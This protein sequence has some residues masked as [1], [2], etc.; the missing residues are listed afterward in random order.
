M[1]NS[2]V[3]AMALVGQQHQ[4]AHPA[5][6]HPAG[7]PS[8]HVG[9]VHAGAVGVHP[10]GHAA[11]AMEHQVMQAI[12]QHEAHMVQQ[13]QMQYQQHVATVNHDL[14]NVEDYFKKQRFDRRYW[15]ELRH[16]HS[17]LGVEPFWR[18]ARRHR[19]I[20]RLLAALRE[21]KTHVRQDSTEGRLARLKAKH[22][23]WDLLAESR[24]FA[25]L[26]ERK[27]D[28]RYW[29]SMRL[30]YE[31]LGADRFWLLARDHREFEPFRLALSTEL[32]KQLL[33]GLDVDTRPE[34]TPTA[35]PNSSGM[36]EISP[37]EYKSGK[38][39]ES[40]AASPK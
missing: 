18:L 8:G 24:F 7:H 3:L 15:D 35:K 19:E 30:Y 31:R 17:R 21:E 12:V 38:T 28:H 16:H 29:E 23:T 2:L 40:D 37:V 39:S 20:E 22:E 34:P 25:F 11:A 27:F 1:L 14:P 33:A 26:K 9:G 4:S 13:R 6:G 36:I 32:R 10:G 5:A